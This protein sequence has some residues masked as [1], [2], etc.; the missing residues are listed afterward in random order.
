MIDMH[1]KTT[2]M[3]EENVT[4][5]Q[6]PAEDVKITEKSG[7]EMLGRFFFDLSKLAFTGLVIGISLVKEATSPVLWLMLPI[8]I[9][10][11]AVFAYIAYRIIRRGCAA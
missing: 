9:I 5:P 8:G 4:N 10:T 7:K 1:I 3:E 2:L 6:Q 11:S